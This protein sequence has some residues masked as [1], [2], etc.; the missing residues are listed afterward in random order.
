MAKTLDLRVPRTGPPGLSSLTAS[1]VCRVAVPMWLCTE[2]AMEGEG[3]GPLSISSSS[4]LY[5]KEGRA[6]RPG[7]GL[8]RSGG[9]VVVVVCVFRVRGG[10]GLSGA[11]LMSMSIVKGLV[12]VEREEDLER[13][14]SML[15]VVL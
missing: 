3:D 4:R 2:G 12:V 11:R 5:D 14:M 1:A 13:L 6:R 9:S 8:M 7:P 15:V 10:M